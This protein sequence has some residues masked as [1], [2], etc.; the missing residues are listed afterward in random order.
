M[1]DQMG[2]DKFH[3]LPL[4]AAFDVRTFYPRVVAFGFFT[5]DLPSFAKFTKPMFLHVAI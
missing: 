1:T 3:K 4:T 5:C 2:E